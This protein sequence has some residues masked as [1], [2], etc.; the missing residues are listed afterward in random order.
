[1][2]DVWT[3]KG[4]RYAFI[5]VS[6]NYIDDDWNFQTIHLSLKLVAWNKF[7]YLLAQPVGRF[8]IMHEL[9]QKISCFILIHP[10]FFFFWN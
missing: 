5:G 3:T 9:H 8:L 10:L 1:M 7:G 6:A 2:H 4:N